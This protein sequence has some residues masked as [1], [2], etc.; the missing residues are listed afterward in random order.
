MTLFLTSDCT[1]TVEPL[2]S[3]SKV[4]APAVISKFDPLMTIVAFP[5]ASSSIVADVTAL[6]PSRVKL[7]MD[8]GL[9]I[10]FQPTPS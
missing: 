10:D 6:P 7:L 1:F 8:G 9:S 4:T 2:V 3:G 5:A